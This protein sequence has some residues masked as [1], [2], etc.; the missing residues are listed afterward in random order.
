MGCASSPSYGSSGS[1]QPR[2]SISEKIG[3]LTR[4]NTLALQHNR[5]VA[6]PAAFAELSALTDL[7]LSHN[8]LADAGAIA[9]LSSLRQLGLSHNKLRALPDLD[10]L[11]D[12][13]SLGVSHNELDALPVSLL[14]RPTSRRSAPRTTRSARASRRSPP[15]EASRRSTSS[16][17]SSAP[18]R[19]SLLAL[20]SLRQLQLAG[21]PLPEPEQRGAADGTTSLLQ[22]MASRPLSSEP[23]NQMQVLFL[24]GPRSGHATLAAAAFAGDTL[25]SGAP[26]QRGAARRTRVATYGGGTAAAAAG[27]RGAAQLRAHLGEQRGRRRRRRRVGAR[28]R[29]QE[30]HQ[31]RVGAPV[32]PREP[33]A[34]RHVRRRRRRALLALGAR[35]L[36]PRPP[37]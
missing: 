17:T 1:T 29:E 28:R 12:L 25:L 27:G 33:R 32:A 6:L 22:L 20:P 10:A 16:T 26:D 36:V 31:P 2:R 37:L 35:R 34:R 13:R 7:S 9:S 30:R 11:H 24:G 4:L 14:R 23:A 5:V 3:S 18:R 19:A 15:S 21:N 8:K